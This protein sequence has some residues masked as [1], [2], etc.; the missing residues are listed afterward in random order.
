MPISDKF[1]LRRFRAA[2]RGHYCGEAIFDL[3][4]GTVCRVAVYRDSVVYFGPV[5][6][7]DAELFTGGGLEREL[8][9]GLR[10]ALLEVHSELELEDAP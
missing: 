7:N 2:K 10:A 6:S 4:S 1:T 9:A 5:G 3:P 8:Q